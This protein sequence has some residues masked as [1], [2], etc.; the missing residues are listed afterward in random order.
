MPASDTETGAPELQ[1]IL[2]EPSLPGGV[3]LEQASQEQALLVVLLRHSGCTFCRE[4]LAKLAGAR[5]QIEQAKVRLVLVHMGEDAEAA[6]FFAK[7][8]LEQEWR[9][10]DPTRRLYR[11]FG[12]RK[13]TLSQVLGLQVFVRGLLSGALWKHGLGIPRGDAF[14][15]PGSFLLHR[16]CIV[17]MHVPASAADE[18]AFEVNQMCEL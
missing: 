5:T 12:L 13:G 9:I 14:Q 15:L 11:A 1:Q 4:T 2:R 6:V 10:A 16:G 18:A 8:N 3:S 17:R 7:Y